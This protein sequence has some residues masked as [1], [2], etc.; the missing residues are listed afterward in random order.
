MANKR[1][2]KKRISYVC[3][4]IASEILLAYYIVKDIDRATVDK[5][6]CDVAELQAETIAHASFSFDKTA[7]DFTDRKAYNTARAKYNAQA[8]AKL[9]KEFS[10]KAEAIIKEMNAA[11]PASGRELLK[12]LG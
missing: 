6:V 10:E 5:I 7:K 3:G 2:L 12:K 9:R 1:Q 11:V 4:E 8:F